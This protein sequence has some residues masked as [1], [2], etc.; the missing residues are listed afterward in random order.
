MAPT[1]AVSMLARR[2]LAGAPAS[3]A[4]LMMATRMLASP[5]FYQQ[6]QQQRGYATPKGAPPQNF[7]MSKKTEWV[8]EKDSLL[9]RLGKYF[10]MTEMARG[11]YVLLEQFF[12][13]PYVYPG[14]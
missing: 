10:L 3:S 7:R 5:T 1:L 12:R 11:M 8:W 6:Q 13:P 14:L 9:D 2:Q 4:S